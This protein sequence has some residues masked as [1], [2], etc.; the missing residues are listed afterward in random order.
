MCF[1]HVFNPLG[2][3][4]DNVYHHI[5]VVFDCHVPQTGLVVIDFDDDTLELN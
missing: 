3:I 5:G 4:V 2:V 1:D